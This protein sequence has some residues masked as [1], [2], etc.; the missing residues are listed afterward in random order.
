M[1]FVTM[2]HTMCSKIIGMC[3][4]Y[5]CELVTQLIEFEIFI[6]FPMTKITQ[7]SISPTIQVWKLRNFLH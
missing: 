7:N 2:L 6:E 3:G 4:W 5:E 1:P